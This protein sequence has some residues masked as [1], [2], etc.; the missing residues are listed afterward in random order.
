M[1]IFKLFDK[2]IINFM[3]TGSLFQAHR[4]SVGQQ[5]LMSDKQQAEASVTFDKNAKTTDSSGPKILRHQASSSSSLDHVQF[6]N[7]SLNSDQGVGGGEG[8]RTTTEE[9]TSTAPA[10]DRTALKGNLKK[11]SRS[12]HSPTTVEDDTG[13]E[14]TPEIPFENVSVSF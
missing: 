13:Q 3:G 9:D 11:F 1:K 7:E 12:H 14:W 5:H 2:V 8:D 6:V 10:N 4:D